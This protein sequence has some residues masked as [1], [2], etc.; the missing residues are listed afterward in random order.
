MGGPE[1][2]LSTWASTVNLRFPFYLCSSSLSL[3]V[4][5]VLGIGLECGG[6]S[7]EYA[8]IRT[9]S[10]WITRMNNRI[11]LRILKIVSRFI[12]QVLNFKLP[13][14]R[15][16]G[17]AYVPRSVSN[18]EA[19]PYGRYTTRKPDAAAGWAARQRVEVRCLVPRAVCTSN[20]RCFHVN[21]TATPT[22]VLAGGLVG[23]D[24]R[25]QRTEN[26]WHRP[27]CH[28]LTRTAQVTR[29]SRDVPEGASCNKIR[30]C[31]M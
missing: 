1:Y 16:Q 3:S 9:S 8:C 15:L 4:L 18:Q 26:S 17:T 10:T 29:P 11:R 25:R 13:I 7:Y 24:P 23:F 21:G 30:D 28:A 12:K 14:W 31:A 19:A 22:A 6:P 27:M 20:Q 5:R 2:F